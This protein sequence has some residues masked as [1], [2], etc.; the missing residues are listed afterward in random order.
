MSNLDYCKIAW[1]QY[2][3]KKECYSEEALNNYFKKRCQEVNKPNDAYRRVILSREIFDMLCKGAIQNLNDSEYPL[4]LKTINKFLVGQGGQIAMTTIQEGHETYYEDIPF[5][6]DIARHVRE[7]FY[8]LL[9]RGYRVHELV[10]NSASKLF[11]RIVRKATSGSSIWAGKRNELGCVSKAFRLAFKY[12]WNW[13]LILGEARRKDGK[14]RN[15]YNS[16][17]SNMVREARAFQ[18][19]FHMWQN[20][21]VDY[22]YSNKYLAQMIVTLHGVASY[23]GDYEAMDKHFTVK[24]VHLAADMLC[25]I[26]HAKPYEREYMHR[27]VTEFM[28]ADVLVGDSVYVG[29]HNFLSGLFPTHTLE[30][31]LNYADL[32]TVAVDLGYEVVTEF[33]QKL[34]PHQVFIG[35]NGDD[36]YVIFGPGVTQAD[37][38]AFGYYHAYISKGLGQVLE[39]S[40]CETSFTE[41][42]FCKN[43]FALRNDVPH[44]KRSV[45]LDGTEY[46]LPKYPLIKA[47]HQLWEPENLP[48]DDW[49]PVLVA[50]WTCSILDDSQGCQN[51]NNV[52]NALCDKFSDELKLAFLQ[53]GS[54]V[55][56]N[57]LYM[58]H[59]IE[60]EI[61]SRD[62]WLS[63]CSGFSLTSSHT[64]LYIRQ[65]LTK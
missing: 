23:C 11:N 3:F 16:P 63:E 4:A 65:Y 33:G 1:K 20:L 39:L 49:S 60:Q 42:N 29:L 40:K 15:V 13:D 64:F 36:S 27:T 54:I 41:F 61:T 43:T 22:H 34:K 24:A 44:F 18:E 32:A 45:A 14:V 9:D 55:D 50:A 6:E 5:D 28:E 25:D 46:P 30:C 57:D 48:D 51:Y 10:Y 35:V 19:V 21:A 26:F 2:V 58:I 53:L 52:V 17:L 47:L 59:N 12:P 31:V 37:L 38:D 8:G 62:W 7:T 56:N